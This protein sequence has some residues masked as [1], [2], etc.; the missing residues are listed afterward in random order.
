LLN[1][2]SGKH[3]F[4]NKVEGAKV[5]LPLFGFITP[6]TGLKIKLSELKNEGCGLN[7]PLSAKMR[8]VLNGSLLGLFHSIQK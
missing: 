6:K 7:L 8:S 5:R 4:N 2:C 3:T 1:A